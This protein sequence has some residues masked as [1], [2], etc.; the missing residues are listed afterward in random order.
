MVYPESD[1]IKVSAYRVPHLPRRQTL[2]VQDVACASS[3]P[4]PA[5]PCKQI[6]EYL[7]GLIEKLEWLRIFFAYKY[8]FYYT[9]ILPW[10]ADAKFSHESLVRYA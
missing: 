5:A 1:A 4:V 8:I 10:E 6:Q 2:E 9:L 7:H 3:G